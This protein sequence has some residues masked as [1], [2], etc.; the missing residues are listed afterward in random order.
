MKVAK[1]MIIMSNWVIKKCYYVVEK[2]YYIIAAQKHK[3]GEAT[4]LVAKIVTTMT[5]TSSYVKDKN[6]VFTEHSV[7]KRKIL[8]FL[9]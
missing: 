5:T 2:N 4:F 8:G 9:P 3:E 7:R 1:I 6:N